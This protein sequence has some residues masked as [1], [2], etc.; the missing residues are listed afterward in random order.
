MT[1]KKVSDT[2]YSGAWWAGLRAAVYEQ[3]QNLG[4][5]NINAIALAMEGS[6]IEQDS[7]GE[8]VAYRRGYKKGQEMKAL[9]RLGKF[10]DLENALRG[11]SVLEKGLESASSTALD[12][13]SDPVGES[14][15]LLDNLMGLFS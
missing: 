8:T 12:V 1:R 6:P 3:Q 4:R 11:G 13:L 14:A 10:P 5:S 9:Y 2:E 7:Y 15:D